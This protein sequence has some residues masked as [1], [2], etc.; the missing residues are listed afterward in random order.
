VEKDSVAAI[1]WLGRA[2][3]SGDAAGALALADMLLAGE[4]GMPPD[5]KN[6]I[7]I[8]T[9]AS[10]LGLAPAQVRLAEV[11]ASGAEGRPDLIRAYALTLAAGKDYGPGTKLQAEL[12]KKMSKEQLAEAQKEFERLKSK[13]AEAKAEKENK[14][15]KAGQGGAKK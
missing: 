6:A 2:A 7:A 1:S 4:G 9:R 15:G 3:G 5:V 10:E 8:L 14:D 11:Y 13:P 12:E